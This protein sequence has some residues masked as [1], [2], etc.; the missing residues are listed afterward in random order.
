MSE[1]NKCQSAIATS[2]RRKSPNRFLQNKNRMIERRDES[3]SFIRPLVLI[4]SILKL[5]ILFLI[6]TQCGKATGAYYMFFLKKKTA[7]LAAAILFVSAYAG[8]ASAH[9]FNG[10]SVAAAA[11][12]DDLYQVQCDAASTKLE[13]S[14]NNQTAGSVRAIVA[15]PGYNPLTAIDTS[16]SGTINLVTC[17]VP[18]P[19]AAQKVTLSGGKGVYSILVDHTDAVAKTYGVSFHCLNAANVHTGTT[20][21]IHDADDLVGGGGPVSPALGDIHLIVNQ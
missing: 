1:T 13:V 6:I 9:C 5:L 19:L 15:K 8:L 2:W 14:I 16:N 4:T 17:A 20:S 18:A 11:S 21:V 10:S 12:N 3:T 7:L